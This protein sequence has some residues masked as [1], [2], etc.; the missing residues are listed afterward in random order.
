[1]MLYVLSVQKSLLS[2][3]ISSKGL[4]F[5]TVKILRLQL[6]NLCRFMRILNELSSHKP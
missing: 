5:S 1:M 4:K 6:I 2:H 3:S